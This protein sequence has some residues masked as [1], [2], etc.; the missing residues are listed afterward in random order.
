M[1]RELFICTLLVAATLSVYGQVARH[2]FVNFDD[3]MYVYENPRVRAGLTWDG[4]AWAFT[5]MGESNW[6]PL[7]WLSHMLDCQ[8]FGL[9]AGS[10][11]LVNVFLHIL[12]SVLLYLI[13][14]RMT[15]APWRSAMVTALFALHPLHVESVAWVSERKDVLSTLFFLLTLWAYAQYAGRPSLPRY[16]LVLGCLALGLT[17]KPMLV[18]VPFVLLLLDY[19]PLERSGEGN[20]GPSASRLIVEK[21]PLFVLVAASSLATFVAQQRG[22]AVSSIHAIPLGSRIE[23]ALASYVAYIG[24]MLWPAR[25]AVFY[26][27]RD[28]V[29]AIQW[30]AAAVTL[31]GITVFV[32]WVGRRWRYLAVGWLWYMGTLVPVIGLVQVGEQSMADRYTYVPLIGLFLMG[33]WGMADLVERG[34]RG[35]TALAATAGGVLL[36]CMVGAWVRVGHWRDEVNL[37]EQALKVTEGNALA[38]NNLGLALQKRGRTE[39]AIRHYREALRID[40]ALFNAH[41]NLGNALREQGKGEEGMRHYEEALRINP[42]SAKAHN[43]LGIYYYLSGDYEKAIQH[44]EEALRI[45]PEIAEIHNNLGIPYYLSGDYEKAIQ[46]Y[47]EALR[48]DPGYADAHYNLGLVQAVQGRLKD[49]VQH[50][51]QAVK[52][53]PKHTKAHYELGVMSLKQGRKDEAIAHFRRVL[54]LDAEDPE[55]HRNLAMV[56]ADQGKHEEAIEHYREAIRL[57]PDDPSSYNNLAWI[58]ATHPDP[59][60]RN[61]TEAVAL[62]EK[63]CQLW[64]RGEV[65]LLDTLAAAFAEAGRFPEAVATLEEAISLATSPGLEKKAE[66]LGR[67]LQ[68]Y[69]AG[70]PYRQAQTDAPQGGS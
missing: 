32:I 27:Y 63:A 60:L 30:V 22:G 10:H 14:G 40:P 38:H 36:A 62:A 7:T 31:A 4:V 29:P 56:L 46:H 45:D 13:L 3:D 39:E 17:A 70:H 26:P 48:I 19:W 2:D 51:R 43:N 35:R 33:V 65:D 28:T 25:L 21:V 23:N 34:Q 37:F 12:N 49:A 15:G 54:A 18:T 53:D 64:G 8:L 9:K 5:T 55:A 57:R 52:I 69:R 42:A 67:R 6:H 47:E 11:H 66:Q 44:Y 68:G 59:G 24:K 1:R 41:G 58:R 61:G 16:G 50:Y 20:R